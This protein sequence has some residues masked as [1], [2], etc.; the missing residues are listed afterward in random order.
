MNSQFKDLF[1][2]DQ[3]ITFLNFGSFGACAKPIFEEYQRLQLEMEKE[4]VQFIVVNGPA[5]LQKSRE[6]LGAYLN[7]NAD[8]LVYVTNP[9]YGLN[10]IAKNLQLK[11]GDEII[12]TD[13][14]YGASDK[15]L[16]YYCKKAGAKYVRRKVS[17]P[18]KSKERFVQDFCEGLNERTKAVF[19]SQITSS[20]GLILPVKEICDIAREKGILTIVDG[21]HVPGQI[22]LDLRALDADIYSG[23]CHKW[24]MTPKGSSFL[25]VRR[26]LQHLFD[27]LVVSWGYESAAPGHSQFIDYHQM[28]GTRDFSAFLTIPKAIEFMDQHQWISV[29][30][31]CNKLIL[32]NAPRFFEL[33]ESEPG[34]PLTNEFIGQMLSIRIGCKE[35]EKLQRTLYGEYKIEIPVMRQDEKVFIRFS[36]NAF[37][38]QSD[39]DKLYDALKEIKART[40]LLEKKESFAS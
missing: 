21:A 9:S 29:A 23:A 20:T 10:I 30:K 22:P 27:P 4:P 40:S 33:L 3:K 18:I 17:F 34:S 14:E 15:A 16:N 24:M 8:D 38:D 12:S 39:L 2:L 6:A 26:E 37:N 5:K 25:Y 36:I 31:N 7:C 28:Q 11:Q 13:I 1:L 35:P 32:D 19:I